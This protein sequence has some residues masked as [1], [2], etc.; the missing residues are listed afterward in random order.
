MINANTQTPDW[1]LL[2][3]IFEALNE[4]VVIVDDQ[5]RIVFANDVP[6]RLSGYQRSEVYGRTPDG[7]FPQQDL[8]YV[9]QQHAAAE[10]DGHRRHEFYVPRTDGEISMRLRI[11]CAATNM[12]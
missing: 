1:L 7:I 4:G 5:L 2:T 9:M 11:F 3:P 12:R 10:R 6:L 8:P